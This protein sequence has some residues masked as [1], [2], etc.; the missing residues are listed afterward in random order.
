MKCFERFSLRRHRFKRDFFASKERRWMSFYEQLSDR[1]FEV[2]LVRKDTAEWLR[3]WK[4]AGERLAEPARGTAARLPSISA[5]FQT[6]NV[7][8]NSYITS[9]RSRAPPD[10]LR[11]E[12]LRTNPELRAREFQETRTRHVCLLGCSLI[13]WLCVCKFS[14][15]FPHLL[16][17]ACA[18]EI[19]SLEWH[20]PVNQYRRNISICVFSEE[21]ICGAFEDPCPLNIWSVARITASPDFW[22][23]VMNSPHHRIILDK[24]HETR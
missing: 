7:E 15:T 12:D 13:P 10:Y 18:F 5:P 2:S 20:K 19:C 14:L 16:R 24:S 17:G 9:D 22:R 21:R 1:N 4:S 11:I 23:I 6:A 8:R 3:G